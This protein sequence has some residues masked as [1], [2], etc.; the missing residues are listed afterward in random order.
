MCGRRYLLVILNTRRGSAIDVRAQRVDDVLRWDVSLRLLV[1]VKLEP[2]GEL[3]QS[4]L[5]V[6]ADFGRAATWENKIKR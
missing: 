3:I 4:A 6:V 5:L 2:L 1:L